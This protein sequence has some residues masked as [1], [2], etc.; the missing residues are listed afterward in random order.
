MSRKLQW[1]KA[2]ISFI[3][4]LAP[5]MLIAMLSMLLLFNHMNRQMR[6]ETDAQQ[7]M[8]LTHVRTQAETFMSDLRKR[9]F[10]L[11][12]DNRVSEVSRAS[13]P[14]DPETI[15][16]A[17]ELIQQVNTVQTLS[18]IQ[19]IPG[20]YIPASNVILNNTS[21]YTLEQYYSTHFKNWFTDAEQMRVV[22]SQNTYSRFI[23]MCSEK[24]KAFLFCSY[25][26][27]GAFPYYAFA[28]VPVDTLVSQL[29]PASSYADAQICLIEDST[30]NVLYRLTDAP[31]VISK[32][33]SVVHAG[34]GMV[35]FHTDADK[36]GLSYHLILSENMLYEQLNQINRQIVVIMIAMVIAGIVIAGIMIRRAYRPIRHL[37]ELSLAQ[38]DGVPI[39]RNEWALIEWAF[40]S[41]GERR[42][43][44]YARQQEEVRALSLK[45]ALLGA[46]NDSECGVPF[47]ACTLISPFPVPSA[48]DTLKLENALQ[49]MDAVHVSTSMPDAYCI[50][51]YSPSPKEIAE[52]LLREMSELKYIVVSA[53]LEAPD[54]LR[55]GYS[56]IMM[57]L[58]LLKGMNREGVFYYDR[59]P[60][61][62]AELVDEV[63]PKQLQERFLTAVLSGSIGRARG[64]LQDFFS[65][66]DENQE[67]SFPIAQGVLMTLFGSCGEIA[68]DTL[69][70]LASAVS[71]NDL[72]AATEKGFEKTQGVPKKDPDETNFTM[73]RIQ[74]YMEENFSDPNLTAAS[75]AEHFAVS[76]SYL[77]RA[78]KR[79][80]GDTPIDYLHKCRLNRAK[81]LLR[82]TTSSVKD[83]ALEVGYPDSG[84]LL[85]QMRKYE[86][87]T[88]GQY[89]SSTL[90]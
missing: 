75:L 21:S 54:G 12:Q 15:Y 39:I 23:P 41:M 72:R 10:A 33:K 50:L 9:V 60:E 13:V 74:I 56:Q 40:A 71:L 31:L 64:I 43:A 81:T 25:P 7:L 4:V 18:F 44:V 89:R 48:Q 30:G 8:D 73:K 80:T 29:F 76:T 37:M 27:T 82:D 2:L 68:G 70:A 61:M 58:G 57:L 83:I 11:N 42:D 32:D 14:W 51:L 6:D 24:G 28:I 22:L 53:P 90:K 78:F 65:R 5:V 87:I 62:V 77:S 84:A 85:R 86:G 46:G 34:D 52:A 63:F 59:M 38:I 88:P 16:T 69:N 1:P 35:H 49:A 79:Q 67:S 17:Y 45:G 20:Y 66:I 55:D 47:G 26:G 3:A 36:F 19:S